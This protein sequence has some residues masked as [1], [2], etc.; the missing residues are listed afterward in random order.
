MFYN[1]LGGVFL[2]LLHSL[3]G[4]ENRCTGKE[5]LSLTFTIKAIISTRVWKYWRH[6]HHFRCRCNQTTSYCHS[7]SSQGIS[8]CSHTLPCGTTFF[9]SMAINS[10]ALFQ[11][12]LDGGDYE[13]KL[14]CE[15]YEAVR[16]LHMRTPKFP[17]TVLCRGISRLYKRT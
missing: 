13:M 12:H 9:W 10:L 7:I 11:F 14:V 5:Y 8:I 1:L 4:Q 2:S 6:F 15:N 16:S 3:F 17:H